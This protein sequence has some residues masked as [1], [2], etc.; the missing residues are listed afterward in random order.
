VKIGRTRAWTVLGVVALVAAAMSLPGCDNDGGPTDTTPPSGSRITNPADGTA[1]N[2]STINVRGRA[3]VGA[4]VDVYVNGGYQASGVAAPA[5]PS[6]GMQGRF[7]VEGVDLGDEGEK[8]VSAVVTDIYG[9]VSAE[10]VAVHITLDQ[11]APPLR[12]VGVTDAVWTDTL[13]GVWQTSMPQVEIVAITDATPT[14]QRVRWGSRE[15]LPDSLYLFPPAQPES[16]RFHVPITVP[17]LDPDNPEELVRYHADVYD[18]ADNVTTVPVDIFWVAAGK[19]STIAYDDGDYGS[20]L[21]S[22]TGEVGYKLAVKFQA[23]DWANYVLGVRFHT[24]NDGIQNPENIMWPTT[25]P[26]VIFVWRVGQSDE[27]P[28]D[29][30][31]N[32]GLSTG[33]P[34]SYPENQWVEFR[35]TTAIN[36][37]SAT[38]FPDKEFFAGMEWQ[39]RQNPLFG[40]DLNI[41]IDYRSYI[42]DRET[43][44]QQLLADVMVRAIVSDLPTIGGA[45]R[46]ATLTPTAGAVPAR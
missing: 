40:L 4:T 8:T 34:W 3:E 28:V 5:V 16:L 18:P 7:T 41:P 43:W 26:F 33:E 10:P 30:P 31:V 45:A 17:P 37:S 2:S 46:T 44:T 23:P 11:T 21:N 12:V 38:Q 6:D 15:F 1:V 29:P 32:T 39:N 9:N 14:G 25:E 36:I 19:E 27:L 22:I 24:M 20:Y 42:Y 35:F 13:G